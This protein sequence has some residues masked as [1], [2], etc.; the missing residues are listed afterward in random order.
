MHTG[1]L[2]T[3]LMGLPMAKRLLAAGHALTVYNR[4]RTRAEPLATDGATIADSPAAVLAAAECVVVM[5]SDGAVVQDLLLSAPARAKLAGRTIIQMST[6]APQESQQLAQEVA[7]AG[8]EY[9]ES[10][11]LGSVPQ[12]TDGQLILMVG[13][14]PAQFAQWEGM[15]KHF[16]PEPLLVGPVGKAAALKLAMNQL[17]GSLTVAFGM[18]LGLVQQHG[19]DVELFMQILRQ[20][21]LYAPTFDKKLPRMLDGNYADPN[22][23][24]K[25]LLKDARLFLAE[26]EGQ[27]LNTT[28]IQ[29][30]CRILEAT[31]DAGLAEQDYAALYAALLPPQA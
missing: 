22:F 8:G 5:V 21:A 17:I 2:G 15:L 24:A 13:S 25:H 19:I 29:A 30:L 28:S 20:S 7:A 27:H 14:T 10:P 4:T 12:A 9:L 23:P 31:L 16:G 26:A 6:I 18:S 1:F 11:V 3:G